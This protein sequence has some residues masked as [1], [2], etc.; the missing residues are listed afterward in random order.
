[1]LSSLSDTYLSPMDLLCKQCLFKKSLA[2]FGQKI[3]CLLL[4]FKNSLY[5]VDINLYQMCDFQ[6]FSP[7][8]WFICCYL[9]RSSFEKTKFFI[10]FKHIIDYFSFL[11][12]TMLLLSCEEIFVTQIHKYLLPF[13]RF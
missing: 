11:L 9:S 10:L 1:M 7:S 6:L 5:M 8:V 2:Y 3:A 13:Y 12:G 4:S